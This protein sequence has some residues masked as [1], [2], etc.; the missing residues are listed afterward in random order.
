M[1]D[2]QHRPQL[3]DFGLAKGLGDD[4][5][6]TVDGAASSARP[7]T[8][9]REQAHGEVKSVGPLSDQYSLGVLLYELLTGRRPFEG[10]PHVVVAQVIGKE[11]PSLRRLDPSIPPD[12]EAI[13]LG[14]AGEGAAP[15]L[16]G[17]RRIGRRPG[18]L[19]GRRAGRGPA[20]RTGRALG[21]LV[22]E[23][24]RPGDHQRADGRRPGAG[25]RAALGSLPIT[26]G[27]PSGFPRSPTTSDGSPTTS[28]RSKPS[29]CSRTRRSRRHSN[30]WKQSAAAEPRSDV[31]H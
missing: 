7:L 12:L 11:P 24:P 30:K 25:D 13:G 1:I 28:I 9:P 4:A 15:A 6:L 18:A 26:P 23:A 17:R 10:P 27:P 8:W 16:R 3:T 22:Q 2:R 29:W 31:R 19:A 21:A 20:S 14:S 5:S